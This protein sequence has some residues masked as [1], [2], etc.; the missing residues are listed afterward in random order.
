MLYKNKPFVQISNLK[1]LMERPDYIEVKIINV[2]IFSSIFKILHACTT[3]LMKFCN[4]H[5]YLSG[6][7]ILDKKKFLFFLYFHAQ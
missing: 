2:L 1:T 7:V 4:I 3:D 6:V 5:I